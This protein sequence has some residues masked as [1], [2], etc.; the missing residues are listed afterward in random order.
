M[1]NENLNS[2]LLI[3]GADGFV[4]SCVIQKLYSQYQITALVLPGRETILKQQITSD[5]AN[6]IK[7]IECDYKKPLLKSSMADITHV[8]HCAGTMQGRGYSN[9]KAAN[10]DSVV[11]VLNQLS[12]N[13]KN[14]VF[15][16]SQ[17]ALGPSPNSTI[18]LDETAQPQPL[19]Y[20]GQ[21]KRQAELKISTS[22]ITYTLLRP[23]PILGPGDRVFFDYF[24]LAQK[25]KFPLLGPFE[26]KF[27]FISLAD[28]TNVIATALKN[29]TSNLFHIAYPQF[30]T[31]PHWIE[32]F[33]IVTR[34]K[35]TIQRIPNWLGKIYFGYHD[36]L[37]IFLKKSSN[38]S[39][40]KWPEIIAPN[41]IMNSNKFQETFK[42]SYSDNLS[43]TINKAWTGY[44][45]LGW[46]K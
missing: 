27:N 38:M 10:F 20:Y 26:K 11:Y 46:I 39:L 8:L 41:W 29:T 15:L 21:T 34:K 17:S 1:S 45:N 2:S 25:S 19:T 31:W 7:V 23:A 33:E 28:M 37:D 30:E 4:G 6:K 42:F 3:T 18:L 35:L 43:A 22:G 24:R 32:Q 9:Y 44:H 40:E 13:I 5:V 14:F 12:H 36:G 16:S